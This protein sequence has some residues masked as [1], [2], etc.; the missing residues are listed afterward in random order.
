MFMGPFDQQIA[1]SSSSIVGARR[2][3]ERVWRLGEKV[4]SGKSRVEVNA[5]RMDSRLRGNDINGILHKTIKKVTGDIEALKYNT[6]ISTLM[7]CVNEMEKTESISRKDYESVLKLTAPFMP[8]VAEELWAAIGN[9]MEECAELSRQLPIQAKKNWSDRHKLFPM[10]KNGLK[11][12]LSG[13]L[14]SCR[15]NW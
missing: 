2:F 11:T 7:I 5:N 9:K 4:E 13:R 3:I 8:H 14:L 12:R 15:I 10:P 1:W 6:A